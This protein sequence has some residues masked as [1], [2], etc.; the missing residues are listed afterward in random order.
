METM[1]PPAAAE[2]AAQRRSALVDPLV[3]VPAL[4]GVVVFM[5]ACAALAWGEARVAAAEAGLGDARTWGMRVALTLLAVLGLA[6]ALKPL[7]LLVERHRVFAV[8]VATGTRIVALHLGVAAALAVVA[9]RWLPARPLSA[10]VPAVIAIAIALLLAL[11]VRRR[12][13]LHP[14][15]EP[16]A[17][18]IDSEAELSRLRSRRQR[19]ALLMRAMILAAWVD[20]APTAE[21]R[22]AISIQARKAGLTSRER[23]ILDEEIARPP[24]LDQL[25]AA[26]DDDLDLKMRVLA[27]TL[28]V[29]REENEAER[30]HFIALAKALAL[31]PQHL[32]AVRRKIGR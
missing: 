8:V 24:T 7:S 10:S 25:V 3:V 15:A 18:T 29:M 22:T 5:A 28:F 12:S 30:A 11:R 21:E 14:S 13:A 9:L 17:R 16:T 23:K 31:T 27:A 32:V 1:S 4:V 2:P 6:L 20:G 26:C 19:E